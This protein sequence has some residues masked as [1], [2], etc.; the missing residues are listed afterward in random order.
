[1]MILTKMRMGKTRQGRSDE[2]RWIIVSGI[3]IANNEVEKGLMSL[4]M[5][6][7]SHIENGNEE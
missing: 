4:R 2:K 6:M 5:M 3:P 1:M 7:V